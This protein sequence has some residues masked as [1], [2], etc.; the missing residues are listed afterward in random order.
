MRDGSSTTKLTGMLK[1]AEPGERESPDK[2]LGRC[3]SKCM[4][5]T[6]EPD[7]EAI[8]SEPGSA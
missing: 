4:I 8:F 6:H 3:L 5:S 1:T 7:A 2:T